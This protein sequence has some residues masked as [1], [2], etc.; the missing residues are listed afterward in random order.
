MKQ[1]RRTWPWL[2]LLLALLAGPVAGGLF[3]RFGGSSQDRILEADQAFQL[4]ASALD[5][6][7]IEVRWIIAPGYYLYRDKFRLSLS[8]TRG[9]A[10]TG[11]ES[12]RRACSIDSRYA[13]GRVECSGRAGK[14]LCAS[15]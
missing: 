3:D 13:A 12:S 14:K 2:A 1:P 15:R 7:T 5:P 11:I 9:I 8:D 4:A 6:S 10:I